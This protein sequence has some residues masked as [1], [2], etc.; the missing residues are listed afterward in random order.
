MIVHVLALW[1]VVLHDCLLILKEHI[2]DSTH[3]RPGRRRGP[4]AVA[5]GH[6]DVLPTPAIAGDAEKRSSADVNLESTVTSV[7]GSAVDPVPKIPISVFVQGMQVFYS[8]FLI[9]RNS[10]DGVAASWPAYF[11]AYSSKISPHTVW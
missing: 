3:L 9:S 8:A 10:R 5:R 11:P 2:L 1:R 7:A 6:A 4:F